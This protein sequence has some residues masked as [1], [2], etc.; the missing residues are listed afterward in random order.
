MII[1]KKNNQLVKMMS[2]NEKSQ[3]AAAAASSKK[4]DDSLPN[5]KTAKIIEEDIKASR[6]IKKLSI[7]NREERSVDY[8]CILRKTGN[9][10]EIVRKRMLLKKMASCNTDKSTR[11]LF[12]NNFSYSLEK[13]HIPKVERRLIIRKVIKHK[14]ESISNDFLVFRILVKI[15]RD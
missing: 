13:D 2:Q 7:T 4:R 10:S 1:K 8:S 12:R 3:S 15:V 6:L 14:V 11:S 9:L 5:E